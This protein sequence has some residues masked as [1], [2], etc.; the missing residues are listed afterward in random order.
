MTLPEVPLDSRIGTTNG[1]RFHL[2]RGFPHTGPIGSGTVHIVSGWWFHPTKR[3]RA[4][5]LALGEEL[6]RLE[7]VQD[8]RLDVGSAL[9]TQDVEGVSLRSGFYGLVP[10]RP[11]LADRQAP[12]ALRFDWTDGSAE[13]CVVEHP[14]FVGHPHRRAST[15]GD[16][17]G[18]G[19]SL[20][21][22]LTTYNPNLQALARQVDSIINQTFRDWVCVVSDDHSP[23]DVYRQVEA[24]CGR[25]QRF[26]VSRNPTN[27]GF[28]RN[29]EAALE[30]A[31]AIGPA[32]V[33]LADQDDYWYPVKL[34][35]CLHAFDETTMLVYCDMRLARSS[36]EILS[37]TYWFGRRNNFTDADVIF[38]ANTV[39]GAASVF[40]GSLLEK[41]L[42]FP[43]PIGDCFHD[44]WIACCALAA[45]RLAYVD[46]PLYE[47]VQ[48]GSNVIGHCS[49]DEGSWTTSVKR[50]WQAFGAGS[51]PRDLVR[52]WAFQSMAVYAYEYRRLELF[53]RILRLRFE[54]LPAARARAFSLTD[55]TWSSVW[56]LC[57]A[58]LRYRFTG[59]TTGDAENRLALGYVL[60][61]LANRAVKWR[62]RRIIRRI[63]AAQGL[64]S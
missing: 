50:A 8:L 49:F 58:H 45:G 63:R 31:L 1:L 15:A 43:D 61:K 57:A 3:L 52:H 51:S 24:I 26:R 13:T 41:I 6:H 35:R 64:A 33:A 29:Y 39:T 34:E 54:R 60:T 47:Y 10:L 27:L 14:T 5:S 28:Y 9:A 21:I 22:C 2:E 32:F 37:E 30:I 44:H 17:R 46:E 25:D 53:G 48:H 11:D 18:E 4:L 7:H 56:R 38:L 40:R 20:V 12:V 16:V 19:A 42:P 55:G 59:A 36:G 62:G 23:E